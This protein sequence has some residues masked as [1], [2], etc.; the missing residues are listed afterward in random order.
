MNGGRLPSIAYTQLPPSLLLLHR[1][2]AP[3]DAASR[4]WSRWA[5]RLLSSAFAF[6]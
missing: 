2:T 6:L 5:E 3:C 1:P 4:A